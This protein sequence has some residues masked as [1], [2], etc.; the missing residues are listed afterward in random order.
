MNN[1]NGNDEKNIN[2]D[3]DES[4]DGGINSNEKDLQQ[5][6]QPTLQQST[7]NRDDAGFFILT[8]AMA[9][10]NDERDDEH[11]EHGTTICRNHVGQSSLIR[12]QQLTYCYN[13]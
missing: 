12:Y 4:E 6:Q 13:G 10:D 11:S 7:W 8:S 9:I 2:N 1:N 3:G 5:W